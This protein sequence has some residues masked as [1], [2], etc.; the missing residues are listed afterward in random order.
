[1]NKVEVV[2]YIPKLL[3]KLYLYLK[4]KFDPQTPPLQEEKLCF[5]ICMS[6]INKE[7]SELTLAPVSNKRF[8]KLDEKDMFI[9]IHNRTVNIINH[10]YS[11]SVFMENGDLYDEIVD[12][13]DKTSEKR[14]Q[15]LEDQIRYNIRHSLETIFEKIK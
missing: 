1:M 12:N 5:D 14:R 3:F 10:V 6:L 9:V 7:H 4:E 13:F 11:Y 15:V 2:G 8:I